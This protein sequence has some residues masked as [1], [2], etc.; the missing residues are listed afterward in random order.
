MM[1]LQIIFMIA[2]K[3]NLWRT[4]IC[5]FSSRPFQHRTLG[6]YYHRHRFF[7]SAKFS[8]NDVRRNI[9]L[10]FFELSLDEFLLLTSSQVFLIIFN[11]FLILFYG[12]QKLNNFCT[13]SRSLR[14]FDCRQKEKQQRI[15]LG[16]VFK[17]KFFLERN[18]VVWH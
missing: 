2:I 6:V 10:P 5:S 16:N 17:L 4:I 11:P 9:L 1:L 7:A 18:E 3:T 15:L 12:Y 8:R 14:F 13:R